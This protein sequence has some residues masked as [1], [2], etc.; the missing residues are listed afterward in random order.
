MFVHLTPEDTTPLAEAVARADVT[1][2]NYGLAGLVT[3]LTFR[4]EVAAY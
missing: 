2:A 1:L 4:Y 3:G